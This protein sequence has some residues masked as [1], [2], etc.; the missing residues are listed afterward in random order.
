MP[1]FAPEHIAP[2]GMN[3][4]ICKSYLAGVWRHEKARQCRGCR[5]EN[6]TCAF[7][8]KQCSRLR[9]RELEFCYECDEFP[10]EALRKLDLSYRKRYAMSMIENLR[11]IQEIGMDPFLVEQREKYRCGS[12]GGVICVHDGTCY[13]CGEKGQDGHHS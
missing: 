9:K 6:R 12:C 13:A 4:A 5:E 3:C 2:C 11:R 7:I 1:D 10:C 8:K